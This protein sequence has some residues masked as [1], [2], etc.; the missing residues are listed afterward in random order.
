MSQDAAKKKKDVSFGAVVKKAA[1]SAFRGGL[2]GLL[3]MVVQVLALM[4][5]RTLVNYQYSKG[6]SFSEAFTTLYN[7]GGIARFYAG[8]W[9]AVIVGPISRFGDTA[10]NAGILALADSYGLNSGASAAYVTA[11]ASF[12]AA[13]WRI[14]ITPISNVKTAMQVNGINGI[15]QLLNKMKTGG[16][17]TLWDGAMGTMGATWLGH[18]PWFLTYNFLV[19]KFPDKEGEG[20]FGKLVKRASIGFC[21]SFVS[22]CVSN[23]LR[24]ITTSMQTSEVPLGYFA[25]ASNIIATDGVYGLFLRGLGTKVISNGISAMLFSVVW[26]YLE[27][28][29]K[30]RAAEKAKA[31]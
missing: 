20:R 16:V 21:A 1:G 26:K 28:K 6:G 4:W 15:P 13:V 9:P 22:D 30:K 27:D 23:V 19:A 7:E 5:M 24:V 25:T 31:Q 10:A 11:V 8:F 3:A 29:L 18:Y 14:F 17:L 2:P 12:G